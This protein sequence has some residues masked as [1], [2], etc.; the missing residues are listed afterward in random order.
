MSDLGRSGNACITAAGGECR[1][2]RHLI[3]MTKQPSFCGVFIPTAIL[4]VVMS[5]PTRPRPTAWQRRLCAIGQCLA[6]VLAAALGA[7]A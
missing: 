3:L 7:R 2:L 1:H 5:D 6:V 4:E